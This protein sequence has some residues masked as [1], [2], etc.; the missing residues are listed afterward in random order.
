MTPNLEQISEESRRRRV[1]VLLSTFNGQQYLVEQL[2]SLLAQR[3]VELDI[4]VRD[5]GSTDSTIEILSHYQDRNL[6]RFFAG[7]NVGAARSFLTLTLL[8][9]DA[10]YYAFSDQD[11]VWDSDKLSIAVDSLSRT[12]PGTPYLYHSAVRLVDE[13]L[14]PL[15]GRSKPNHVTPPNLLSA[16]VLNSAAGCTMVFNRALLELVRTSRSVQPSMHD[17]WI[18]RVCMACGG[19]V[20]SDRDPHLSYRQHA[21]NAIGGAH[22]LIGRANRRFETLRTR[23]RLRENDALNILECYGDSLSEENR[24]VVGHVAYYRRSLRNTLALLF[25]PKLRFPSLE[26]RLSFIVGVFS[27]SL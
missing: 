11:D 2:E 18:L 13:S 26:H 16:L 7:P 19:G 25:S 8:A 17:A 24:D 21:N 14:Q 3:S 1:V 6:L 23:Q 12:D 27:H 10:D 20:I 15:S 4:L 9:G 5:D 22:T